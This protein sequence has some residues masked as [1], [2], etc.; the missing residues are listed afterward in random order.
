MKL[1][2]QYTEDLTECVDAYYYGGSKLLQYVLQ[3]IVTARG[4]S[5]ADSSVFREK[6]FKM[7][8]QLG[9]VEYNKYLC[10]QVRLNKTD[11][12]LQRWVAGEIGILLR[13]DSQ[14]YPYSVR[15]SPIKAE[16]N[17][18]FYNAGEY[19]NRVYYF[20]EDEITILV[21]KEN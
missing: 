21:N 2:I 19:I 13:T 14:K 8:E 3:A 16:G 17:S 20:Y 15:L 4:F 18:A 5:I 1:Q 11:P 7:L 6:L 10:T 9:F 12:V